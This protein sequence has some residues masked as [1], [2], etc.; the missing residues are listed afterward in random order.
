MDVTIQPVQGLK[1]DFIPPGD[2]SISHRAIMLGA[3]ASGTSTI[4]GLLEA[5]D[6]LCTLE[7]F[8]ALGVTINGRGGTYSIKGRCHLQE[9]AH[10]LDM[11]NSGTG[12]RLLTGILAGEEGCYTLLTGDSSLCKRPMDRIIKPL[13]SMGGIIYGRKNDT[14]PPLMIKGTSLKPFT[15]RLPIPSAQVKSALL[16]A[17]L[18]VEGLL[19]IEE[20]VPC[21]DHT[22]RMMISMGIPLEK[23]GSILSMRGPA[24]PHS[25]TIQIPGDI[26]SAAF[27]IVAALLTE[28]SS[29]VVK[30]VGLNPTRSAF[31]HV[32]KSMGAKITIKKRPV[33]AGEIQGDLL[34]ESS[35]LRGVV[36]EGDRI[37]LLID[38]IPVLVAAASLAKGT[39][40]IRGARELRYKESDRIHSLVSEF[41]KLGLSIE[42]LPDG[43]IIQGKNRIYGGIECETYEDHRI[44]MALAVVGLACEEG[45]SIH[46]V[47]SIDT[48]F[49]GFFQVIEDLTKK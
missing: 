27:F 3:L 9:P 29:L 17:G 31:L 28:D 48:S 36:I 42:E 38:E 25:F 33:E 44:G 34:V 26:S 24:R 12:L 32:L 30:G 15:Y 19:Q 16:F 43:I 37:P 14:L 5:E 40:I 10:I 35:Q 22:E 8:R 39:T 20:P 11:G 41:T 18:R 7:A 6:C 4:Y 2:K 21:R 13:K 23:R 46:G 1:G 49:P 45:L 47:E